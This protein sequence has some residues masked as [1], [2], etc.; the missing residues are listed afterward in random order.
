MVGRQ[1]EWL[2]CKEFRCQKTEQS[3]ADSLTW[4]AVYTLL[5]PSILACSG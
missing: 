3:E 4:P 2:W 1:G 5:M